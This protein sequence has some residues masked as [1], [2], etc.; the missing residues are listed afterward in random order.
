[1]V[2]GGG[3]G[4]KRNEGGKGK[5][6]EAGGETEDGDGADNKINDSTAKQQYTTTGLCFKK[7][8]GR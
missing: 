6:R 7:S 4:E 1:M 2:G 8:N 3:S 5:G